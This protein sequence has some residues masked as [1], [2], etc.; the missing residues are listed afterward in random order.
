MAEPHNLS[1]NPSAYACHFDSLAFR[2]PA[3]LGSAPGTRRV[4]HHA[5]FSP[6]DRR[7]PSDLAE[8]CLTLPAASTMWL[9]EGLAGSPP[10]ALRAVRR[11]FCESVWRPGAA[12]WVP[13]AYLRWLWSVAPIQRRARLMSD[14]E[15]MPTNTPSE[16]TRARPSAHSLSRGS[17]SAAGSSG[18]ACATWSRGQAMSRRRVV[19]W[20]CGRTWRIWLKVTRPAGVRPLSVRGTSSAG[21]GLGRC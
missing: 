17:R 6:T 19:A 12:C 10:A 4:E 21:V 16:S 15:M 13:A 9:P 18:R 5:N 8:S 20:S 7:I 11:V 14:G 2:S 1:A 3:T